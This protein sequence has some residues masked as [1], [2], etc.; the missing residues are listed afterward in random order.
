MY[1]FETNYKMNKTVYKRRKKR[2]TCNFFKRFVSKQDPKVYWCRVTRQSKCFLIYRLKYWGTYSHSNKKRSGQ[3]TRTNKA[4][5]FKLATEVAK[6]S[7]IKGEEDW[8]QRHQRASILNHLTFSNLGMSSL[9]TWKLIRSSS[10]ITSIWSFPL[11]CL[12]KLK[13]SLCWET[14]QWSHTFK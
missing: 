12:M 10:V 7:V 4:N 6:Y 5:F 9:K 1:S 13:A 11:P 2:E 8:R 3:T 14:I